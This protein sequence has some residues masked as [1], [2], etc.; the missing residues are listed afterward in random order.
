MAIAAVNRSRLGIWPMLVLF[1]IL[2]VSLSLMSDATHN[3][4]RF[5]QMYSWLLLLNA[6]GLVV[7]IGLIS[8]N[9]FWLV[10]QYRTRAPGAR[11]TS[12]LVITFVIL[13][14]LPIA[15]V[16]YFSLQFLQRGIDSWFDVQI[17]QAL[18]DALELS[19]GALDV[20]LG[21]LLKL[22]EKVATEL[23]EMSPTALP[24][25]LYDLR[26]RSGAV[27]LTVF[28]MDGR[29]VASSSTEGTDIIP[30]RP[31]DQ[32]MLSLTPGRS[33]VGLDPI[34]NEL[35]VRAVV[36]VT[37]T[38]RAAEPLT[39]QA[40]YPIPER[41]GRLASNVENQ[42][43]RYRK[44]AYLRTPLKYSY[45]LTLSL[46]V[47]LSL[48]S[49][50]W[51]AFY[52]ARRMVEPIGVL[53]EGTRAVAEGDYSKRLPVDSEDELGFLVRSF[54][55]MTRRLAAA[56]D[57]TRRGQQEVESQRAYLETVLG[58]LSS[59][60]LSING[61][62]ELRTVNESACQILG[63]DLSRELGKSLEE[64]QA[65]HKFLEPL[66]SLVAKRHAAQQLDWQ[67]QVTLFDNAGRHVL[68]CRST[69]L[70]VSD[71]LSGGEVIVFDDVTDLIRAQRDAAW[72]EVARRLAHEIKNPLTPIQ[73]SAERLR[74][75]YLK[76]M[77]EEEAEILDRATRTIV[78]QV[79]TL[80]KMVNAFGD[81]A[82]APMLQL[83]PLDLHELIRDIAEL[84]R[85]S[86][87]RIQL[88]LAE[89]SPMISGDAGRMRQLLHNLFKN[90]LEAVRDKDDGELTVRSKWVLESGD[91]FI[92]VSF[93]D[94]GSGFSD[95]V[96]ERLFEPYV[97]TKTRGTG[98]GLAIVKKIVEEHNG[99]IRA[100]NTEQ[101]HASIELRFHAE[102]RRSLS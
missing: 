5:G 78:Q 2:L 65:E 61:A 39:L 36:P 24:F 69:A 91:R 51:V 55:D 102:T 76:S 45:T 82:R 73:L 37:T 12:R 18:D 22:T 56:R 35:F 15:V 53:A 66:L 94:N 48:L 20:R 68:M 96:L 30:R 40:L 101:H 9:L 26:V 64:I 49:A 67:E 43:V 28:G 79:D 86:S 38:K 58:S 50:V 85:G 98:L 32:A 71:D 31:S 33:Y 10:S 54:N 27:E 19:R 23:G 88:D 29:I 63:I 89:P 92:E 52:S 41:L 62:G 100:Q 70:P 44:L 34:D 74:H 99:Q 93:L 95:D 25:G 84:Y 11:L 7:L 81:Y 72:G 8:T 59:G 60:V 77:D 97:T 1:V 6:L 13:A 42:I 57:Q 87:L 14:V 83:E 4:E 21:D 90:A 80:K 75:K 47:V 46:V 16:Y 17:E 3:S